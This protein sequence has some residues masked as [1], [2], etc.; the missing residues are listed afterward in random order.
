MQLTLMMGQIVP[1]PVSATVAEALASVTVTRSGSATSTFQL[2]FNAD[3]A[4][5]LA[6]PDFPML[7]DR[8]TAVG[9]RVIVSV[10]MDAQ[11]T[12][13]IDGII[14]TQE[15]GH[16]RETGMSTIS[17]T[18]EDL[19][20]LMDMTEEAFSYPGFGDMTIVLLLLEKY[21]VHGIVP[22][23]IPT[24]TGEVTDPLEDVPQ[25]NETDR[26]CIKR[27]ADK[28]GYVFLMLPGPVAG[29]NVAYWG[30]PLRLSVPQSALTVDMGHATN[31]ETISFVYNGLAA[32]TFIGETYDPEV[33]E[34]FPVDTL[35]SLRVPPLAAEPALPF[36]ALFVKTNLYTDSRWDEA[37]ALAFA[38]SQ[39]D[40]SV[41][42]VVTVNGT[43]DTFRYGQ[44]IDAP[45]LIGVRGAGMT[46][47]GIYY[48]D[49]V[50]HTI[51]RGS[52]SQ[53][54]SLTREGQ[55]TTVPVVL[56]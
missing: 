34:I 6:I 20:I 43:L 51:A 40:N 49:S 30:P 55:M 4:S 8:L 27:L 35:L 10:T 14:T 23:T 53:A 31:V 9:S 21:A 18:G 44:I 15:L 39:T 17:V 45:G 48:V 29:A 7:F 2:Q 28:H 24:L 25:Q 12:V 52:Y 33:D 5:P 32:Q 11:E 42:N 1:V 3:R 46:N 47:D 38:Q 36:Q 13:L 16:Q 26:A 56:T 54:F 22:A 19:S 41:D 37:D 50:T